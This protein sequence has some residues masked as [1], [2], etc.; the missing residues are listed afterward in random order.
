MKLLACFT[1]LLW[2]ARQAQ[3]L[4]G[5]GATFPAPLY[6]KWIV[7]FQKSHPESMID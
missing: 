1:I 2:D 5:A 4:H 3:T 7:S 6:R